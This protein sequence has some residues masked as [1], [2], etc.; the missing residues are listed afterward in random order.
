MAKAKAFEV[1]E[2]N[3]GDDKSAGG[4]ATEDDLNLKESESLE[5]V[6]DCQGCGQY[7]GQFSCKECCDKFCRDCII[8]GKGHSENVCLNCE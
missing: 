1:D 5:T 3:S 2:T 7:S 8:K 4:A 6:H